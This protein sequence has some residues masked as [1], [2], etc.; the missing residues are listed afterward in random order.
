[1]KVTVDLFGPARKKAGESRVAVE[2]PEGARSRDLLAALAL[3]HPALVGSVIAEG[4]GSLLEP[5]GLYLDGGGF[6]GDLSA[7][8]DDGAR[9]ALMFASAGGQA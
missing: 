7:P 4:A 2:L 6:V 5:Y 9:L 3:C 8:L 1:M